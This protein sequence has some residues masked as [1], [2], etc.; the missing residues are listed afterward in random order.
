MADRNSQRATRA[1]CAI[2]LRQLQ[3]VTGWT[4]AEVGASLGWAQSKVS[5]RMNLRGSPSADD[6]AQVQ[7]LQEVLCG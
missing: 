7:Q 2:L 4:Q 3:A 6:L 5:R 1:T